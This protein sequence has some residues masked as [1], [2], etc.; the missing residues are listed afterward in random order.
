MM[1]LAPDHRLEIKKLPHRYNQLLVY[2][3]LNNFVF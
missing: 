2:I 1:T 3:S